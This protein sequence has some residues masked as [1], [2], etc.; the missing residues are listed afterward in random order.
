ML[1]DNAQLLRTYH[2]RQVTHRPLFRAALSRRLSPTSCAMT[3]PTG[4]FY[5]TQDAD[6]EGHEGKFFV[7]SPQEIAQ[8]LLELQTAATLRLLR[9]SAAANFEGKN[10]S[11]GAQ[12]GER[13]AALQGERG[14]GQR[15]A[16]Y[17]AVS[18]SSD[19][20]E[21]RI[22]PGCDEKILTEWNGLMDSR[23]G[24]MRRRARPSCR[25]TLPWQAADFHLWLI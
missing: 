16:G 1:Y 15:G 6:S 10:I 19:R 23:A 22:K 25:A 24:R 11:C 12:R 2:A 20:R 13:G 17:G 3:E 18:S 14:R 9:R 5:S 4:G 8:V 21:T 7:R